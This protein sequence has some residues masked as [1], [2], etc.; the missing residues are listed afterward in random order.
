[1]TI[2]TGRIT[3]LDGLRGAAV[4]GILLMNITAFAMPFAAYANPANFGTLRWPDVVMWAFG[5]LLVDGKMRAIFSALFG[6]SLLLIADRAE[7]GGTN[8]IRLHYARSGALLLIGLAHAC[9]I[10]DGD[11]LVLYALVG[12]IAFL[13]RRL[14]TERMLILAGLLLAGQMAIYAIHYQALGALAAAAALPGAG[15]DVAQAWRDVL[16]TIGRP[17]SSVLANDLLIHWGPWRQMVANLAGREFDTTISE[18]TFNGPETLGLMLLGMAGLRLGFLTGAWRRATYL[19]VARTAYAIGLP[20]L[21]IAAV[22]L[23]AEGFPP[24]LTAALDDLDM[25]LRWLVALGHVALLAAWFTGAPSP[26]KTR[27]ASA[28]RA[29]LTNYLGTSILMTAIFDGWGLGLYGHVERWHLLPFVFG[30][31]AIMLLWSKPW[32]DRFAYGPLEWV[33]R[34][35]ARGRIPEFRRRAI[36]S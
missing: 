13:F 23:I 36:E 31:W 35:M 34:L 22:V 11:I 9:L 14:E 17:S 25:P 30:G 10:W 3:T 19:R 6:A 7:V 27:I 20:L 32:L 24:L 16:D 8:P 26:L 2:E 5:F 1:L 33:W 15:P 12:A 29:A 21:A 28:G 4:M 18:L